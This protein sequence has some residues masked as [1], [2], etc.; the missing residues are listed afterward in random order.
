MV[1]DI[2]GISS[3]SGERDQLI[4]DPVLAVNFTYSPWKRWE[5]VIYGDWGPDFIS[6]DY[7]YQYMTGINFLIS[8]NVFVTLGYRDH[9]LEL[10]YDNA[11]Y[12]GHINGVLFRVGA[13][14]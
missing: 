2:L 8:K 11:S 14:F 13:Q 1:T 4:L 3:Y 12:N 10:P 5:L 9:F 7:T 6:K